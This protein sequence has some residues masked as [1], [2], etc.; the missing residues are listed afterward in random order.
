MTAP[1]SR[2]FA[3]RMPPA[4]HDRLAERAALERRTVSAMAV[5]LLE[6]ALDLPVSLPLPA[7][8]APAS[9]APAATP[10]LPAQPSG[11]K[12]ALQS[13]RG[14]KSGGKR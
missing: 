6:R 10:A 1:K 2:Y 8:P 7:S 11:S 4:L 14:T 13:I 3:V 12:L 5:L 9:L